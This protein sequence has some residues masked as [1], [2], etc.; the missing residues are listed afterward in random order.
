MGSKAAAILTF[1]LGALVP[2]S[3]AAQ[4]TIQV[5]FTTERWDQQ[6]LLCFYD[7][8]LSNGLDQQN[9]NVVVAWLED[10]TT[11]KFVRTLH[12]RGQTY[13]YNLEIW[14]VASGM[15]MDAVSQASERCY[16]GET[17]GSGSNRVTAPARI[18][19]GS[20]DISDLPDGTYNL[21]LEMSS[22]EVADAFRGGGAA[23]DTPNATFP[24]TKGRTNQVD[25]QLGNA[26]PFGDV[27]V[28]YRAAT[29]NVP[30]GVWAGPRPLDHALRHDGQRSASTGV[31]NDDSGV[32]PTISWTQVSVEPA[33]GTA[34][35]AAPTMEV[36]D[37]DFTTSGIYTLRMT[38][39]DAQGASQS[40]DVVVQ[41]NVTV[42]EPNADAEVYSGNG[43]RTLGVLVQNPPASYTAGAWV[44]MWGPNNVAPCNA[45][46]SNRSRGYFRFDTT[47]IGG[48]IDLARLRLPIAGQHRDT[49]KWHDFYLLADADD[50]WVTNP[51][52]E[53]A[54]NWNNQP[55]TG[56]NEANLAGQIVGSYRH[57]L[58]FNTWAEMDLDLATIAGLDF[59]GQWT[60]F[61][62]PRQRCN[63]MGIAA[64]ENAVRP[65]LLIVEHW[66]AGT[67]A[68][69]VANAGSDQMLVDMD[70]DGLASVTLDGTG[71]TDDV[72]VITY[73]W[74]SGGQ[75]I[76]TTAAPTLDLPAGSP[77]DRP[78][79]DGRCGR[80]LDRLADRH[81]R[82]PLPPERNAGQRPSRSTATWR[83]TAT[84]T[85]SCTP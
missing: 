61:G 39:T 50:D 15:A 64:R 52:D 74:V 21:R 69:P 44:Y 22:C 55:V 47:T 13:I 34:I 83:A 8:D 27:R 23:F 3:A 18:D 6:G 12:R 20:V 5:S 71:S 72:A 54:V 30:P 31:A 77:H 32:P 75:T 59:N 14:A 76:G 43:N 40:D 41:V 11:G 24:F 85:S 1:S 84:T 2:R 42:L 78:D 48:T 73:T 51:D 26:F 7:R 63:G 56:G 62:S 82:R 46:N 16:S 68:P 17:C 38:A 4:D 67:N 80:Q 60:I 28:D 29:N 53:I 35:F 70:G 10:A 9:R 58:D 37:V 25:T 81:R 66:Q 49:A 57:R 19:T 36:T 45:N 33:G 79:G 65:Q